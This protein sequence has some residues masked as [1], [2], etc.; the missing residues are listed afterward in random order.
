MGQVS[1]G[2]I[3]LKGVDLRTLFY[4]LYLWLFRGWHTNVIKILKFPTIFCRG[5]KTK[6]SIIF[7][8]FNNFSG[9]FWR[10]VYTNFLI[11][12]KII[13]IRRLY[14]KFSTFLNILIV[15][16]NNG[17][18]FFAD[19]FSIYLAYFFTIHNNFY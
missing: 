15:E 10:H 11:F 9:W 7:F 17:K 1:M 8:G 18:L 4:M 6:H 12:L 19:G 5:L 13:D 3:T 16:S 2:A 14:D